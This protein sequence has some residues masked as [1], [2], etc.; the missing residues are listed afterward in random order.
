MNIGILILA[1]GKSERFQSTGGRGSKL[2]HLL[3]KQTVFEKTL[4]N[5]M[6]SGLPVHVVTRADNDGGINNCLQFNIPFSVLNSY[7]L[8]ESI[9][10]GVQNT[11]NWHGWLIQ[12]G[13]MPY[14]PRD[15]FIRIAHQ[16]INYSLVRPVYKNIP[17][18]PVGISEKYRQNLIHLVGDDGAKSILRHQFVYEIEINDENVTKDFDYLPHKNQ[19]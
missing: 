3:D 16:F 14:I 5:S 13:D 17:G 11:P 6:S 10:A 4:S 1:A 15:I 18:H 19:E 8:G 12:L 2:N 9:A 7:G